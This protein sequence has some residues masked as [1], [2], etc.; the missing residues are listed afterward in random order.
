MFRQLTARYGHVTMTWNL[1]SDLKS[2][3]QFSSD[4]LNRCNGCAD[5]TGPLACLSSV[6]LVDK[7]QVPQSGIGPLTGLVPK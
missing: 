6:C 3:I 7:G 1:L 5:R 2:N 4:P